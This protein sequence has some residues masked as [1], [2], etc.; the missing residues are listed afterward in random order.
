MRLEYILVVVR[1]DTDD[2]RNAEKNGCHA[3][4]WRESLRA[5]IQDL[6]EAWTMS[7]CMRVHVA[8]E[9]AARLD[10]LVNKENA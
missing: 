1:H 9:K 4:P 8:Y 2:C 6:E 7:S 3:R 5:L 10:G